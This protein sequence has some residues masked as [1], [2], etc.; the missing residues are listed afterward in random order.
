MIMRVRTSFLT[1]VFSSSRVTMRATIYRVKAGD[2]RL[3]R[4][5]VSARAVRIG[6]V[7]H[8]IVIAFSLRER[9]S[10][11]LARR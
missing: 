3:L 6:Y 4:Q 8:S 7:Y 11:P 5:I 9:R 2:F 10:G 1:R